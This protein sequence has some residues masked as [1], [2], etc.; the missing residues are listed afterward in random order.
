MLL[1]WSLAGLTWPGSSVTTV[2]SLSGLCSRR[3]TSGTGP[4][5]E[6]LG[7]SPL[8][9]VDFV[10]D[11]RWVWRLKQVNSRGQ[12]L[13]GIFSTVSIVM[14]TQFQTKEGQLDVLSRTPDKTMNMRDWF[15][16]WNG[17][18]RF[19]S[20]VTCQLALQQN[21]STKCMLV[22]KDVS[23]QNIEIPA[24]ILNLFDLRQ[25]TNLF[26]M[27]QPTNQLEGNCALNSWSVWRQFP[28]LL[29]ADQYYTT[30]LWWCQLHLRKW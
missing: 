12:G 16:Y 9:L 30:K 1:R 6:N 13:F 21:A 4:A 17:L 2:A 5:S 20:L 8:C 7:F 22:M 15:S 19:S 29:L 25:P 14:W 28:F 11:Q 10:Q 24:R 23:W 26:D 18:T 3:K 27:R